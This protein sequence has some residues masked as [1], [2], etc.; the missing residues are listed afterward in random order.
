MDKNDGT[1]FA[2]CTDKER[3]D[4]IAELDHIAAEFD[5]DTSVVFC[6]P[7]NVDVSHERL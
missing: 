6:S 1:D 7:Y 5:V 3:I 4:A 2:D